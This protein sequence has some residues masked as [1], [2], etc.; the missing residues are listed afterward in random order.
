MKI[1]KFAAAAALAAS[2][3]MASAAVVT[4]DFTNV[5]NP[6]LGNST[7]VNNFYNGGTSGTNFGAA[8]SSNA[9]AINNFNG[10]CEPDQALGKQGILFFLSGGAVTLDYAAGFSN[11]FS[12]NC[13]SNS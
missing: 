7:A 11:G 4:L 3:S 12:F 9:L 13:S 1:V 8:F 5:V 10:C 6:G 2:A